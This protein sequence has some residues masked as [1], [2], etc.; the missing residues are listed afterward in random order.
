MDIQQAILKEHSKAQCNKIV[1]YIGADRK[2][3]AELMQ[4]FFQGGYRATQ[5]AAW[6]LSYCANN[7]PDLVTPYLGKL[8]ALLEKPGVHNAVKRNIT[9]LLQ[10]VQIPVKYHGKVMTTCF[11]F[12]ADVDTPVAIKAFSLTL[13]DNLSRLYPEIAKELKLI[14]EERWN[15]ESPAFKSRAR[16]ILKR[17]MLNHNTNRKD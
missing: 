16:K 12:I 9:R 8:V 4:I 14:I 17:H 3:F 6:P 1:K 13:L 5:R 2:K 11:K 15:N 10:N 7:H